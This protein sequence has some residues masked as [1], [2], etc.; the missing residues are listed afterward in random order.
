MSTTTTG[1]YEMI[2]YKK[3][4]GIATITFNRPEKYNTI[5]FEM[6]EEM[7]SALKDANRDNNIKVIILEGAGDSFC[8][9]FDFS[10]GLEHFDGIQEEGYSY[11]K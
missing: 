2:L 10:D 6:L 5:R 4:A 8:A 11:P 7:D 3:E 9:G 1:S